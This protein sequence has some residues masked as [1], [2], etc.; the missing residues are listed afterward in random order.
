MHPGDYLVERH[1]GLVEKV[2]RRKFWTLPDD[3]D[4]DELVS[5]GSLGLLSAARSWDATRGVPFIPYARAR[6]AWSISDGMRRVDPMAR[7]ARDLLE[8]AR[9]LEPRLA[10]KLKRWPSRREVAA[11]LEVDEGRLDT[12][13]IHGLATIAVDEDE[14]RDVEQRRRQVPFVLDR[15]DEDFGPSAEVGAALQHLTGPERSVIIYRYW[16]EMRNPEIGEVFGLTQ[17]RISQIHQR[18]LR[19]LDPLLRDAA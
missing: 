17:G 1:F 4:R 14:D 5:W 18:G 10:Q 7:D 16:Y 13:A 12:V 8:A 3:V 6:I 19:K 11:E 2:I 15:H 9:R